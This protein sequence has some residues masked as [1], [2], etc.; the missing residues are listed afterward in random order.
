[1][2]KFS[3]SLVGGCNGYW[4]RKNKQLA[5]T[6]EFMR[7][8]W[9][10]FELEGCD[11]RPAYVID[12]GASF[13][14]AQLAPHRTTNASLVA[15][16][17]EAITAWAIMQGEH[18]ALDLLRNQSDFVVTADALASIHELLKMLRT[19]N[20]SIAVSASSVGNEIYGKILAWDDQQMLLESFK[21]NFTSTSLTFV[22]LDCI[23]YIL[24]DDSFTRDWLEMTPKFS[25]LDFG[26]LECNSVQ[27][28]FDHALEY[29]KGKFL[30]CDT[31][32]Y[33]VS[34]LLVQISN[35]SV[36]VESYPYLGGSNTHRSYVHLN[37]GKLAEITFDANDQ[38]VFC[39][40]S[41]AAGHEGSISAIVYH[42]AKDLLAW[43]QEEQ[44][45]V[46]ML[47]GH[48][49]LHCFVRSFDGD[50]VYCR[51]VSTSGIYIR[52]T[53]VYAE[54]I[55]AIEYGSAFLTW[56]SENSQRKQ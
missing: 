50:D 47:T 11:L 51:E 14:L 55:H 17:V 2:E 20:R 43:V 45:A 10:N 54:D 48:G 6:Y 1:M 23:S 16:P 7:G 28:C 34:G 3:T 40:V 38:R 56:L 49:K 36:L 29:Y 18:N 41:G 42:N 8:L 35:D 13:V 21:P 52:D 5:V 22:S 30:V 26:Y 24:L 53:I 27:S 4:S 12:V 15:I 37:K 31:G 33:S 25:S 44:L 19:A 39:G 32:E 46:L 9:V